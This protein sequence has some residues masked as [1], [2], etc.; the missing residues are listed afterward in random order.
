MWSDIKKL[1]YFRVR[2]DRESH[3]KRWFFP[4]I[5]SRFDRWCELRPLKGLNLIYLELYIKKLQP[6]CTVLSHAT[7]RVAKRCKN[8]FSEWT[9]PETETVFFLTI[10]KKLWSIVLLTELT[11]GINWTMTSRCSWEARTCLRRSTS[12]NNLICRH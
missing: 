11:F 1:P 2:S 10:K 3:C 12:L 8:G 9:S 6:L 7:W 5:T 4:D